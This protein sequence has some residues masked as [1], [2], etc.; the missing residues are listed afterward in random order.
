VTRG[1][2]LSRV[3]STS[4]IATCRVYNSRQQLIQLLLGLPKAT[5]PDRRLNQRSFS[6]AGPG[7]WAV[8]VVTVTVRV[9][10]PLSTSARCRQVWTFLAHH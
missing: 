4:L 10:R 8:S 7:P 5:R 1:T 6:L 3:Q 9:S 2:G